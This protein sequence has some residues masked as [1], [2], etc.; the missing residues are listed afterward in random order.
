MYG[1]FDGVGW[2]FFE[3]FDVGFVGE[4]VWVVGVMVC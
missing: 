1:F 3:Y 4:V 2:V